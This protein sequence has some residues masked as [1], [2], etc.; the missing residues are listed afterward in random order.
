M[1]IYLLTVPQTSWDCLKQ[2]RSLWLLYYDIPITRFRA[3]SSCFLHIN[4]PPISIGCNKNCH[5]W[6]CTW[7]IMPIYDLADSG[8]NK[9]RKNSRVS[10]YWSVSWPNLV[11][12]SAS[13]VTQSVRVKVA[14]IELCLE[15]FKMDA[16][17]LD[18]IKMFWVFYKWYWSQ[19]LK[20]WG[21][22][23][24][25]N[26]FKLLIFISKDCLSESI[27][28]LWFNRKTCIFHPNLTLTHHKFLKCCCNSQSSLICYLKLF[29]NPL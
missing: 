11:P 13:K 2:R 18:Q 14:C 27:K 12:R 29:S 25:L 21:N 7:R 16:C 28:S 24:I 3:N 1:W 4:F 9:S 20:W 15:H 10:L 17:V 19:H 8:H 6:C 22:L 26:V 23:I 5:F